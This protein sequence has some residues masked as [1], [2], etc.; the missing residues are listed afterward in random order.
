VTDD[1]RSIRE[2]PGEWLYHYTT[3]ETALVYVLSTWRLRLS[4]F[5][6]MRD[7]REY[8][9][10]AVPAAGFTGDAPQVS[11]E[12]AWAAANERLNRLKREFKLLSLT[13]DD[14]ADETEYGRGY[15]RSR[16]W[17]EYAGRGRGVCLTFHKQT[18]IES[19]AD[20]LSSF[21][22]SAHG[23]VDYR[24]GR[25][26]QEIFVDLG[27]ALKGDLEAVANQKVA[28]HLEALFLT[29][30]TE[31]AS[32][33]EYRFIVRAE[34]EEEVFVN[35]SDSLVGVCLGP[36]A[37]QEAFYAI[38][39]FAREGE[40]AIGKLLWWNNQPLLVGIARD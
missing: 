10:W 32:E 33:H 13:M 6:A 28:T 7:P 24:N 18:M 21:Q 29:K 36:E 4:P 35:V 12:Q 31:W 30:N 2:S 25:L 20:Q 23:E 22:R 17:Q 38:R 19:L 3:L 1:A 34:P 40:V 39:H 9:D 14:P 15:A 11:V 16:L 8:T 26:F 27:E 37:P 5:S